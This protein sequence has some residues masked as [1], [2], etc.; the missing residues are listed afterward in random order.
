M[1]S[2]LKDVRTCRLFLSEREGKLGSGQTFHTCRHLFPDQ[3]RRKMWFSNYHESDSSKRSDL[4][5]GTARP[6]RV[7]DLMSDLGELQQAPARTHR[8]SGRAAKMSRSMVP[9]ASLIST[10]LR[11][12]SELHTLQRGPGPGPGP[13]AT[14][15]TRRTLRPAGRPRTPSRTRTQARNAGA[16]PGP[17]VR[18]SHW[19][20]IVGHGVPGT[21]LSGAGVPARPARGPGRAAFGPPA[22][23]AVTAKSRAH[24]SI[25]A[26]AAGRSD[27]YKYADLETTCYVKYVWYSG[28]GV[29]LS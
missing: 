2:N 20:R 23:A 16:R 7:S 10:G 19:H 27:S 17:P 11:L 4:A 28:Q 1:R 14:W 8:P 22:A 5:A 3:M 6:L 13:R 29:T 24:G 9:F 12:M 15:Q 26:A 21:S 18:L 25:S